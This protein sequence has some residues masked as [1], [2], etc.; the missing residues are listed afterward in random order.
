MT[1]RF[2]RLSQRMIMQEEQ[3]HIFSANIGPDEQGSQH[4]CG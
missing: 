1:E 2:K 4:G 3:I